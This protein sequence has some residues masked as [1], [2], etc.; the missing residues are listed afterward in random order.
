MCNSAEKWPLQNFKILYLYKYCNSYDVQLVD[1]YASWTHYIYVYHYNGIY[2]SLPYVICY[3]STT[4]HDNSMCK[5]YLWSM[6]YR[7]VQIILAP[8]FR[9]GFATSWKILQQN[10]GIFGGRGR[11]NNCTQS[12]TK[13]DDVLRSG[14]I[15]TELISESA[16]EST[17]TK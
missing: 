14:V 1:H 17:W 10:G 7:M 12:R 3:F 15:K 13:F 5:S 8:L 6:F 11:K 4:V 16:T 9:S 2:S